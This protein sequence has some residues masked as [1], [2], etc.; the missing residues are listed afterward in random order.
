MAGSKGGGG[1][2]GMIFLIL[3]KL[4]PQIFKAV[5]EITADA[6]SV[7]GARVIEVVF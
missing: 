2:E 3:G 4:S 1:G 5:T 7:P 6:V